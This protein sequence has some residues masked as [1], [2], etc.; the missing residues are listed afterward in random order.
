MERR[1]VKR[2]L[3]RRRVAGGNLTITASPGNI[4]SPG[5][6][7]E[8]HTTFNIYLFFSFAGKKGERET[9]Y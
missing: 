3:G 1:F 4:D 5:A 7:N 2:Y 9:E 6:G 8:I